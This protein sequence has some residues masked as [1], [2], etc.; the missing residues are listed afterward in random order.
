MSEILFEKTTLAPPG[1][2]IDNVERSNRN[3]QI[4]GKD[5]EVLFD[6]KDLE[7]P[8]SWSDDACRIVASKY[9]Y[10]GEHRETSLFQLIERV[11][12]AITDEG[13]RS[14]T[15]KKSEAYIF[16]T[17]LEYLL[18]NQMMAFNSPV[19]FNVGLGDAYG[20]TE[21]GGQY[22]YKWDPKKRQSVK[23]DPYLSEQASAC[24]IVSVNDS[25]EDIW[26]TMSESAR[27]FKYGSGIGADWSKLR[28][29]KDKL[30]GGGS[31]SGPVSFMRVQDTTGSTIKSGGK[32]RRAAIMQT[33]KTRHPDIA[34]FIDVKMREEKKA[35][36][37]IDAG[38]DGS[39]NGDAYAT[40]AFQNVNMSVRADD[41]FLKCVEQ[42]V[43]YGHNS[44]ATNETLDVSDARSLMRKI[45]EGTHFC[46][47]PGMQYEDTIQRW[48]TV[49]KTAPINSSN[50]CSEYMFID[51]SACNLASLNL[52]KFYDKEFGLY[53][54]EK[55][56]RASYVTTV[57]ME[58][59]VG[60]AG[61]PSAKIAENSYKFRP[62]GLGFA[63]LG[64]TLMSMG[65]PYNSY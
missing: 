54:H 24:F 49:P 4:I 27:L 65:L 5:G 11:V 42:G 29:T 56:A 17:D 39:F 61:Y 46:G 35:H 38:Y 36:A 43:I 33:L 15:L 13:V 48:H 19:W 58:I 47:D 26:D 16:R 52:I 57:A 55:L 40:V 60:R 10:G 18:V 2:T 8:T 34:E 7:F 64:G 41:D 12:T 20:I 30:S 14:K 53:D 51:D 31:P 1:W 6:G 9:F 21:T 22:L 63:N 28:S 3:M 59:L 37:L 32:T 45:C 25:I 23:V 62:L 44:P 50:P